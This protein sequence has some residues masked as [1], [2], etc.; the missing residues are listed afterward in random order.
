[1]KAAKG[2]TEADRS[3]ERTPVGQLHAGSGGIPYADEGLDGELR[4]WLS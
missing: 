2:P 3:R 1:M 4:R